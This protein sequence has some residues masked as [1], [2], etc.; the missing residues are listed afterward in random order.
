MPKKKIV[1]GNGCRGCFLT[2]IKWPVLIIGLGIVCLILYVNLETLY[3]EVEPLILAF[4]S[5]LGGGILM[6]MFAYSIRIF[7]THA[8]AD[9]ESGI[10][11]LD[12]GLRVGTAPD[13]AE[14][15]NKSEQKG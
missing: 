3:P 7:L 12:R 15:K 6:R 2:L 9:D 4:L 11:S 14:G 13:A 1:Y 10:V 8:T 5:G